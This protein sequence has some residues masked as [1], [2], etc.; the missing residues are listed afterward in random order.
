MDFSEFS[1][2]FHGIYFHDCW[3]HYFCSKAQQ[4]FVA[5]RP[6][7]NEKKKNYSSFFELIR[8][9]KLSYTNFLPYSCALKNKFHIENSNPLLQAIKK[10]N[11]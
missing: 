8:S 11:I 2:R 9:I 6:A 5:Y 4:I 10:M 3:L 7:E 1:R